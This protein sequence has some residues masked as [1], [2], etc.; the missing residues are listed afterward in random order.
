M[1]VDEDAEAVS[2]ESAGFSVGVASIND[3]TDRRYWRD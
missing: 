1:V 2:G 3:R